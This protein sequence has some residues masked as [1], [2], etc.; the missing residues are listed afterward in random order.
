[1]YYF[2]KI[3]RAPFSDAVAR[4]TEGLKAEGFCCS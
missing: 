3:M 4:V 1:M 2:S